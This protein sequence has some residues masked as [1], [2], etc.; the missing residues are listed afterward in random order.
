MSLIVQTDYPAAQT[1]ST[2][3]QSGSPSTRTGSTVTQSGSPSTRTGSTVTQSG[4]PSAWTGSTA[5]V[6]QEHQITTVPS[7]NT[8][9]STVTMAATNDTEVQP[10]ADGADGNLMVASTHGTNS[11]TA[12]LNSDTAPVS[13]VTG[14][15]TGTLT[16]QTSFKA[17]TTGGA[18]AVAAVPGWGIALLVLASLVLLLLFLL[19]IGLL[20]WCCYR[21]RHKSFSPYE[22]LD[23]KGDI[24]LYTTHGRF[25]GC[26]G[27]PE[28]I[29]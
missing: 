28:V 26:N 27:T 14:S 12:S 1:G 9:M 25:E 20:L 19:L 3:T 15:A 13:K 7:A 21:G 17:E 6:T 23:H 18:P 29:S 22:N 24:P 10:T 2:V 5:E 16:L 8:A 4:S 11:A